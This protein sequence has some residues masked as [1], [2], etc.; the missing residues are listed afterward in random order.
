MRSMNVRRSRF[1]LVDGIVRVVWECVIYVWCM[2][3]EFVV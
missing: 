3:R 2:S 1:V